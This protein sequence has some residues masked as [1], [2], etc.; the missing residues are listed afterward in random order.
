MVHCRILVRTNGAAGWGRFLTEA[1]M[2]AGSIYDQ[3]DFINA[4]TQ[5][6]TLSVAAQICAADLSL[7]L[8][9]GEAL[10]SFHI[11]YAAW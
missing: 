5:G 7:N 11:T 10:R 8:R 2:L 6:A 1:A 4:W 9:V 3:S